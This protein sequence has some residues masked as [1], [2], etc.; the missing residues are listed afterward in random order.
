MTRTIMKL[1]IAQIDL[2][3]GDLKGN[4]AKILGYVHQAK[5]AGARLVVTPE[6][7]I[8]GYPPEDLLLRDG[9]A[10]ACQEALANLATK[11]NGIILVIGH[12][13]RADHKLYNAASVIRDGRIATTYLKTSLPNDSVFDER[14]Y[15]EPGSDPC[16]FELDGIKF[17]VQ[18]CQ[19]IWQ[20]NSARRTREAGANVLLVLNASPYHMRKQTL[21]YQVVRQQ[22]DEIG[23]PV[24]YANLVG[25]QDELV[26][27]GASFAIDAEGKLT[28]QFPAF[29]EVLGLI[30]LRNGVPVP[31]EIAAPPSPEA[32]IYQAV[33]LGL[34]TYVEKNHFPGVVLGLSGGVDSALV[35]AIAVDALGADR[36]EAVMMPSKFTADISLWDARAMV[37]TLNVRYSEIGIEPVLAQF[38]E[39]LGS[40]L[41]QHRAAGTTQE[42]LQARIRGNMLMALSN[43]SGAIVLTTGNKSEIAVGYCTLYGDMAGGFAV[44]KDISKTMV[45]RLCRYRNSLGKVIPERIITRPPSAELR[46][47]QTDQDSLPPYDVLDGIV[48]AYMERNLSLQKILDMNYAEA[49]VRRVI[50]LIRQNE[51]KRRQSA[52]GPRITKRAFGK[53]W[54]YPITAVYQDEF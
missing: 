15:F 8:S 31:V 30:D 10:L 43:N 45:Y 4:A 39:T 53:D 14:R 51:Y 11:I 50:D 5:E 41:P 44:L 16:I 21:R 29:K 6:L 19:D 34:K 1:A 18:I 28:H 17:G 54:R 48:E 32:E 46:P 49:D 47:G 25:A 20:G 3:V 23:I 40:K 13:H 7:A 12:P 26:F 27:D 38:L 36:V 9:F 2:T 42:N 24:I 52:L 22:T 33:C 35:M 37:K